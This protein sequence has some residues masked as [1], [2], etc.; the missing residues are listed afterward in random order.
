LPFEGILR[1]LLENVPG[2]IGAVFL[3]REGE[4]V[5]LWAERVFEIGPEGLRAIGAYQ[6]IF[7][8]ELRRLCERTAAGRLLRVTI[9][10]EHVKLLTCDLKDGYYLVLVMEHAASEGIA[11]R[12][13]NACR[14]RLVHEI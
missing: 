7:L 5:A 14:E 8:A 3:D 4:S 6:G 12:G 10:F 13:L 2:S 9:D 11:W 1:H